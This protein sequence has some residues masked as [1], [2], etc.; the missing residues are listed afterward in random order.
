MVVDPFLTQDPSV[1]LDVDFLRRNT[2]QD[3]GLQR[4]V[5]QIFFEQVDE[6]V[7]RL[8]AAESDRIW[9]ESAHTIKGGARGIGLVRLSVLAM[10]AEAL[11]G[12]ANETARKAIG[13]EIKSEV[14]LSR[15]IAAEAF[16]GL[17]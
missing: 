6:L 1:S 4:D 10:D 15:A 12:T 13:A 5:L 2:M 16:P 11:M 9:Y 14:Q 7:D 17:F 3:E 8:L